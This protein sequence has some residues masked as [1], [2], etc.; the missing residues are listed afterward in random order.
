MASASGYIV[1]HHKKYP[2]YLANMPDEE[3]EKVVR[4]A[5]PAA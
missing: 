4:L 2:Y 5:C 3:G 1:H